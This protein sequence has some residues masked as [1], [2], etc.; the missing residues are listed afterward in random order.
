MTCSTIMQ[1]Y[2]WSALASIAVRVAT[3]VSQ[4]QRTALLCLASPLQGVQISS[5]ISLHVLRAS[6]S[7]LLASLLWV[8]GLHISNGHVTPATHLHPACTGYGANRILLRT[9]W[10]PEQL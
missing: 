3:T 4:Q 8:V 1:R 2:C 9:G 10:V 6:L 5:G 7:P